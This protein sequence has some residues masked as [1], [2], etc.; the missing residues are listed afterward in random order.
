MSLTLPFLFVFV[1]CSL[2]DFVHPGMTTRTQLHRNF[3]YTTRLCL[4]LHLTSSYNKWLAF[5]TKPYS[6]FSTP[7]LVTWC[8]TPQPWNCKLAQSGEI[9]KGWRCVWAGTLTVRFFIGTSVIGGIIPNSLLGSPRN[10][11]YLHLLLH[12]IM[13]HVL[14]LIITLGPMFL[15]TW[16]LALMPLSIFIDAI[17]THPP[18]LSDYVNM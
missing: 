7:F 13:L 12:Q 2:S 9:Q 5:Q 14:S 3:Q 4:C 18:L 16:S 17:T 11:A 6:T 1:A 15:V 10:Q 8:R